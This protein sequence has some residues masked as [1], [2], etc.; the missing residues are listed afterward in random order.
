MTDMTTSDDAEV[1]TE[2]NALRSTDL[3]ERMDAAMK[4]ALVREAIRSVRKQQRL[5]RWRGLTHGVGRIL[6]RIKIS[7]RE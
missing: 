5:A 3:A 6:P 4:E 7:W 1:T 2:L